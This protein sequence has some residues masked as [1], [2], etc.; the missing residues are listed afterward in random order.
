M[1]KFLSQVYTNIRG[2]VGG[3]TYTA[4]QFAALVARSRVSP[5]NPATNNQ[6]I[7]RGSMGMVS[8]YWKNLSEAHRQAWDDYSQ[9]CQYQGAQGQYTVPGR[10][11]FCGNL[12]LARYIEQR[13]LYNLLLLTTPPT[14][15]GFLGVGP[16]TPVA[17]TTPGT[18]IGVGIVN[19]TSEDVVALVERSFAFPPSR[20][21][22]KGPYLSS[23]AICEKVPASTSLVMEFLDLEDEAIYFTRTRC[24]SEEAPFRISAQY[25]LRHVAEVVSP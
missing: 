11:T 20:Y 14:T 16:I 2:S 4:N 8:A 23:T 10:Q 25:H 1:A 12:G 15:A 22:F 7:I 5:V 3:I 19:F 13:G 6:T 9:T 17:P 21:R 24:I 18:G